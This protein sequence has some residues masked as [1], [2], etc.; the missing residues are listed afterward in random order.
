MIAYGFTNYIA[1]HTKVEGSSM[2]DT[3]KNGDYLLVE[4]IS[5]YI[6]DPERFDI[7]VFPYSNNVNYIKRIIGMP[8][9]KIQI[10]DGA[11][12]INDKIMEEDIY[13]KDTIQDAGVAKAAVYLGDDEYFVLGDNREVSKDSRIL[14]NFKKEEILGKVNIRFYPLDRIGKVK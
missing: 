5:Y 7:I 1:H 6:H 2:N 3:L 10:I 14:G 9:E 4:K 8:G 13:G 12:Y 11:V